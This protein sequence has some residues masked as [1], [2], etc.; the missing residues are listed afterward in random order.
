[1]PTWMMFDRGLAMPVSRVMADAISS[2]RPPS[3]SP[4]RF[5]Y[6]ARSSFG[7]VLH[8]PNAAFAAA[9][10]FATSPGVPSGIVAITSSVSESNTEIV[11]VP[12]EATHW[13]LM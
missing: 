1:M 11:V 2:R 7:S 10:A 4:M 9:A 13:P 12:S 8:D 6:L 3:A 5:M